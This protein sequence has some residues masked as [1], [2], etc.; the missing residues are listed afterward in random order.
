MFAERASQG[1]EVRLRP[2]GVAR[3]ASATFLG[4][5]LCGWAVGEVMVAG[6]LIA[7][8]IGWITGDPVGPNLESQGAG[9]TVV[10]VGFLLVWLIGWTF[11]GVMAIRQLLRS[12]WAEDRLIA[13]GH[14]LVLER[15]NGPFRSQ[16]E[17][18]RDQ[19]LSIRLV[20]GPGQ[21]VADTMTG[22]I[23]LSELGTTEERQRAVTI[24]CDYLGL[25]TDP[26]GDAPEVLPN[27][28]EEVITPEGEVV[29]VEDTRQ[30][31]KMAHA[32]FGLA[33][34]SAIV[35][36]L[37]M[38]DSVR[39]RGL[40]PITALMCGAAVG[41][42]LLARWLYRTRK[43]WLTTSGTLIL[44]KRI[45]PRAHDV[46]HAVALELTVSRD[47]DNDRWYNLEAIP[48]DP[49]DKARK[50]DH[51]IHDPGDVRR[52]GRWIARRT[53]LP[54]TDRTAEHD[55][56]VDLDDLKAQLYAQGRLGRWIAGWI[57]AA[58]SRRR[59]S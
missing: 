38:L 59:A 35:G 12:V 25:Q 42:G 56:A 29:L 3:F 22:S 4:V 36:T 18:P 7:L 52:L 55:T 46:F 16:R 6:I 40:A 44:R 37:L 19:L 45:G 32:T 54:F 9:T 57:E 24:L 28:W 50:V 21:I 2:R 49:Q 34:I 17:I 11:G 47:G 51:A 26:G 1:M 33:T 31:R 20:P 13:A 53:G 43:E 27:G 30:R 15:R 10:G 5:W 48:P 14:G 41:L 8:A 39:D 23:Q 58:Q